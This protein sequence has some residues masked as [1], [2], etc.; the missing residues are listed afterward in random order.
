MAVE[1]LEQLIEMAKANPKKH[2]I[3]AYGQDIYTIRA[4]REAIDMGF[5]EAT[6]VGDENV[7]K[8]ICE[9]N[10]I[11]SGKFN[12]VHEPDEMK[13]GRL[14]VALINEG[15]GDILMK[16]LI[17]TDKYLKCILNKEEGLMIPKATLTH[18]A[19]VQVPT[20]P[21]LMIISDAAFIPAPDINQKIAI[22]KYLVDT[23]HQLGIEYP[24]V[25]VIS[26]TEKSNPKVP[27]CVDAAII[28][29]M[30]DRGQI[31]KAYIDG[32]LALDVAID[33]V[34][35]KVKGLKSKV[36]GDA[37][38][39]VFPNLE[40]GNVFYKAM[41]KLAKGEI[42]AYVAGTKVPSILPSRGDS[43]K[44]KL[45]SIAVACLMAK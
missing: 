32:P 23:A 7:I 19:L 30:G 9:K 11:D 12:I 13:S 41:T 39:L 40:T 20:Y 26:F 34:S 6:L 43:E 29:K 37:D 33:P 24:K 10:K 27:S 8:E 45:Y 2:L 16:G 28:A 36:A 18:I 31:K 44:S 38:C 22:T 15:K 42:A 14:S 4:I 21:K 3:A 5:L 25:A 35:V 1:R 17:S